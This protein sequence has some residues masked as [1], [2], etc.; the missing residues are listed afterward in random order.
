MRWLP[1]QPLPIHWTV[2]GISTGGGADGEGA[3]APSPVSALNML[4]SLSP[5]RGAPEKPE[6]HPPRIS[7]FN[8]PASPTP[9]GLRPP[10]PPQGAGAVVAIPGESRIRESKPLRQ[11]PLQT[12]P[13]H[14]TVGGISTGGGADGEGAKSLLPCLCFQYAD[15]PYPGQRGT[16]EARGP[17][18]EDLCSQYIGIPHPARPLASS[19]RPWRAEGSRGDTRGKA[20]PGAYPH[21]WTVGGIPTGG[22]ADG[23]GAKS[24]L[25][26]LCFQCAGILLSICQHPP[27]RPASGLLPRPEG[28]GQSWR[29]PG[30]AVPGAYPHALDR[31]RYPHG[32][33]GRRGGGMRPLPC[34]CS[35]YA[36]IP[37]PAPPREGRGQS[38]RYPGKAVSR[39]VN[40]CASSLFR[41]ALYTGPWEVSPLGEGQ[42]GR[43]QKPPPLSLLSICWHPALNM[44]ASP[45]PPGLRPPPPPQGAGAVV[46]IPGESRIRESK[47]LRQLP[48]QTRPI[49][50][51]VGGIPT[52]GGADGEGAKSPLPCLCFQY[53]DIPYPGQRGTREARGPPP[54]DLCSQ[55]IGIPH[56]ARPPASSPAP[57]GP[58]AVVAIPGERPYPGRI[59]ITGPWEVSPLGEGQTGRGQKAPSPVSAFNVL[60]SCSQ[61][62]GILLSICWHPALNMLASCSQYA[63]IPHPARPPASSPAPGGPGAVVAIPGE[64]RIRESK[65][66]HWTVGGIPTGGGADG[67]G[68]KS[69][70]PCL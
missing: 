7:D 18:P 53:A 45:T 1:L 66:I 29:Y 20:V 67:E 3:K 60:A 63:S 58:R 61:Y 17:P 6:D 26:C 50:W 40:P 23:E 64:G 14:W 56:P 22:G 16:R 39:R 52:G 42:T 4:A 43:R 41:L 25:P 70:L 12:R 34:L 13:I 65:P 46:A 36:S 54:E 35:Q 68:A 30:K 5:G 2:G 32:G 59:P 47:P 9:P 48:L 21:N 27:P 38:W 37:H 28:R 51:T 69:P 57:G 8:M 62:A 55:Y 11:L 24:P 15:I 31:G 10:P 33:R 44:P 19:P 49:H